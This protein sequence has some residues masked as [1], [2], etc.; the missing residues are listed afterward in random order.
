MVINLFLANNTTLSRIFY[1]LLIIDLY[2]SI[3]SKFTLNYLSDMAQISNP[4]AKYAV[5]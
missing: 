2:F 5:P 1:I 4:T 3:R